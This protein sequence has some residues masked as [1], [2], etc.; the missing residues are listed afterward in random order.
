MWIV[1]VLLAALVVG[2]GIGV[3]QWLAAAPKPAPPFD[4]AASNGDA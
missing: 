1:G 3:W 4:L 2:G